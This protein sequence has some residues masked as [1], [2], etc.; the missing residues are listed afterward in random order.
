MSTY[1]HG[2]Y[3]NLTA[4]T[5][6]KN[7]HMGGCPDCL[8]YTPYIFGELDIDKSVN[9]ANRNARE[10]LTIIGLDSEDLWGSLDAS[11]FLSRCMLA[12]V[13]ERDDSVVSDMV[14]CQHPSGPR[15]IDMGRPA[16]YLTEKLGLL[17][18]VATVALQ[19]GRA[20]MWS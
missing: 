4:A 12:M 8:A 5:A 20:V 15:F 14:Y 16:G 11:D 3:D 6:A 18:D 10:L 2:P 1:R 7:A 17:A 9:V 13:E 19:A